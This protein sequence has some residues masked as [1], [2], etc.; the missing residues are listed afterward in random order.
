MVAGL[1]WA[2]ALWGK[3]WDLWDRWDGL[4]RALPL[5]VVV[6]IQVSVVLAVHQSNFLS[7]ADLPMGDAALPADV[8]LARGRVIAAGDVLPVPD[9]YRLL[10]HAYATFFEVPNIGG[11][12]P[13]V[14]R[15]SLAFSQG[16]DVPNFWSL[17]ITPDVLAEFEDR[18]VRYWI[19]PTRSARQAE[20]AK[21]SGMKLLGEGMP[22]NSAIALAENEVRKF[23]TTLHVSTGRSM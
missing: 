17:P 14:S 16:M 7:A 9:A 10:T 21:M 11:Y 18:A 1:V 13:L 8:D 20:L 12:N 2:C 15:E 3:R 23:L 4:G 22:A 19:V 6:V 5:A